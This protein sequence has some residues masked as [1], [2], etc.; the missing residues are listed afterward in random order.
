MTEGLGPNDRNGSNT[1]GGA[2]D[3]VSLRPTAVPHAAAAYS[4]GN[5][6]RTEAWVNATGT[7]GKL[8]YATALDDQQASGF[9]SETVPLYSSTDATCAPCAA[10]LG[11][12]FGARTA[13]GTLT[14]AFSRDAAVT[15]RYFV[16]G[17]ARDQSSSLN[18]ID[19][20]AADVGLTHY[21]GFVGRAIRRSRRRFAHT[22]CVAGRRWARASSRR[23]SP[24]ATTRWRSTA[25]WA[26]PTMLTMPTAA[27]ISRSPGNARSQRPTLPSAA[28]FVTNR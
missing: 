15:A 9:I 3:L 19:R 26:P 16:L 7:L 11:S 1:F 18:G 21:G 6:G 22:S 2:I 27:T 23:S 12:G 24:R 28:T 20:N 8:G 14:Y 25:A 17:D 10:H 4:V 13:L 5:F